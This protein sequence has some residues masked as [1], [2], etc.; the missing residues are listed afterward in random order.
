MGRGKWSRPKPSKSTDEVDDEVDDE[1]ATKR[2]YEPS[3]GD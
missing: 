2:P 1:T 3:P